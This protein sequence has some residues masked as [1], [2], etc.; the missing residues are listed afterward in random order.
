MKKRGITEEDKFKSTEQRDIV[1]EKILK[2]GL[3]ASDLR[4]LAEGI[5]DIAHEMWLKQLDN[6]DEVSV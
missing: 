4:W 1:I 5:S 2:M 6:N 3:T